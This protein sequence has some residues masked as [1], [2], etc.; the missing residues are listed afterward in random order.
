MKDIYCSNCNK[1]TFFRY[2]DCD[3]CKEVD[4]ICIWICTECGEEISDEKLPDIA[5]YK[6]NGYIKKEK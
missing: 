4:T 5:L 6:H 1:E 3:D 2:L